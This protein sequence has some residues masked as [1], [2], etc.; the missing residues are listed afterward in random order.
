MAKGRRD[1]LLVCW[2][3]SAWEGAGW[4]WW[5]GA[6]RLGR[7]RREGGSVGGSRDRLGRGGC[8]GDVRG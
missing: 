7:R 6:G 8:G 1:G 5:C 2:C 3:V 4:S